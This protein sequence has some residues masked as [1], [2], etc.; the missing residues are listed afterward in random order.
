MRL[1]TQGQLDLGQPALH[2]ETLSSIP[3]KRIKIDIIL[4]SILLCNYF[5]YFLWIFKTIF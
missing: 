1:Y 5:H 4:S 3:A 2:R